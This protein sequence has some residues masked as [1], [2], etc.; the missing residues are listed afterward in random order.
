MNIWATIVFSIFELALCI[1][2]AYLG[3]WIVLIPTILLCGSVGLTTMIRERTIITN[4][5]TTAIRKNFT[6]SFK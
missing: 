2:I 3:G 5:L 6:N 1:W 4:K